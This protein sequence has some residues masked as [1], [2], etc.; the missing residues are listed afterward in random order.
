MSYRLPQVPVPPFNPL[1]ARVGGFITIGGASMLISMVLLTGLPL[2]EY[3]S[4]HTL[5]FSFLIGLA[6]GFYLSGSLV[7]YKW[8]E[9]DRLQTENGY[10][11]ETN[12]DS[13]PKERL[14]RIM[15]LMRHREDF[16]F[17]IRSHPNWTEKK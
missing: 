8:R 17:A 10:R 1:L 13:T 16:R 15:E 12:N 6:S 5:V 7:E 4:R 2:P 3:L 11:A 14:E 9:H